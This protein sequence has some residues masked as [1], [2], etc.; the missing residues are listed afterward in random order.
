MN[1]VTGAPYGMWRNLVF[2]ASRTTEKSGRVR[3]TLTDLV[4]FNTFQVPIYA[5][6]IAIGS[7]VQDGYV[8]WE[9]VKEGA[10]NLAV[11]S[12]LIGP[13]MGWYMDRF[14][15]TFGL[16]SAPEKASPLNTTGS[17]V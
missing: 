15:G 3:K 9:K 4:A 16:A 2:R 10:K 12:P 6:A 14:R 7:Y 11:I 5:T 17:S 13:T 1:A 8:D